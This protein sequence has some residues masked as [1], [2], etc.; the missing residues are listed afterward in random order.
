MDKFLLT[1]INKYFKTLSITGNIQKSDKYA[2][3][4]VSTLYSMFNAFGKLFDKAGTE[5]LNRYVKCLT[6][7]KCIFNKSVPCFTYS[8]PSYD[9]NSLITII[10]NDV[11]TTT[12]GNVMVSTS[13]NT[14]T[15]TDFSVRT[16]IQP[17]QFLVGYDRSDN[18][19]MA[20]NIND[21]GLF[22]D[23]DL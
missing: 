22:W 14:Q 1:S 10:D 5:A 7:N 16:D 13:G 19:E 6:S 23:I 15:F 17:D 3:F 20:V 9:F 11:I 2:L 21:L 4:I 18:N 12:S 8:T